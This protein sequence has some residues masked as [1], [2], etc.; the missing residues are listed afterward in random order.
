MLGNEI[1][2]FIDMIKH[3]CDHNEVFK[4]VI[5]TE[6]YHMIKQYLKDMEEHIESIFGDAVVPS[7]VIGRVPPFK[8]IS[9][10]KHWEKYFDEE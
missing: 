3:L 6:G 7:S 1:V 4:N 9:L 2:L 5:M 10:Y 8:E